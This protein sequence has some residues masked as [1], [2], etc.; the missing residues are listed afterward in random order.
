MDRIKP[1]II[2]VVVL[3]LAIGMIAWGVSRGE[4]NIVLAKAVNVCLECI[5]LGK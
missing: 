5:G 2:P 1:Y 3:A 4:V